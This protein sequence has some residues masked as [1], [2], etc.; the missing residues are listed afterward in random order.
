[1][2]EDI[3]TQFSG[4][5]A[6]KVNWQ[7]TASM[8]D[9]PNHEIGLVEIGGTQTSTDQQWSGAAITYWG[10]ADLIDG[11]GPQRGYFLNV[12]TDNDRD[13]GSFEAQITMSGEQV[14]LEGTW[15]FIGGTGK[16]EGISG[17]GTFKGRMTSP[18]AVST[19]WEGEYHL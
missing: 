16:F 12:H 4:S 7:T 17:S 2:E 15:Q 10:T 9:R 1:M 3:M 6:G 5:F 11:S 8:P 14:T 18:T 19:E 13:C